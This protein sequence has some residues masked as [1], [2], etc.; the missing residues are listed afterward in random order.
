MFNYEFSDFSSFNVSI[1][2]RS[3]RDIVGKKVKSRDRK[4]HYTRNT[5]KQKCHSVNNIA[6]ISP[7]VA[8]NRY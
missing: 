3:A 4:K 7:K 1:L 2:I 6:F 5:N 8:G